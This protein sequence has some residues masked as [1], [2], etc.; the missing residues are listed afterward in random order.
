MVVIILN[1]CV[2]M[3]TELCV[4]FAFI[5]SLMLTPQKLFRQPCT[6]HSKAISRTPKSFGPVPRSWV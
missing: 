3:M 4:W 1:I 2:R 6:R 5:S